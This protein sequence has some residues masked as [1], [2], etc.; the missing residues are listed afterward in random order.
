MMNLGSDFWWI[1][2]ILELI[3]KF[4]TWLNANE[5]GDNPPAAT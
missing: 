3:V 4:F 2:R 1:I 5:N